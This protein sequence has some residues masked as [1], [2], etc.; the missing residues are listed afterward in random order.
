M[1]SEIL[2]VLAVLCAALLAVIWVFYHLEC[3]RYKTERARHFLCAW[4]R[5]ACSRILQQIHADSGQAS[6]HILLH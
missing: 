4:E 6:L 2:L 5:T 1:F 3:V